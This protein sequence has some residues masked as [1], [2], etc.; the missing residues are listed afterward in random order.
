MTSHRRSTGRHHGR[1]WRPR[2]RCHRF[3]RRQCRD[4]RRYHCL[5]CLRRSHQVLRS[6]RLMSL[7]H[8]QSRPFRHGLI[9][10]LSHLHRRSPRRWPPSCHRDACPSGHYEGR[11]THLGTPESRFQCHLLRPFQG[12]QYFRPFHPAASRR[13][14]TCCSHCRQVR[15]LLRPRQGLLLRLHPWPRCRRSSHWKPSHRAA[16]STKRAPPSAEPPP[17][18]P[19]LPYALAS[20][21]L[22]L[23]PQASHSQR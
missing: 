15:L 6:H 22:P 20:H 2:T 8:R 5:R 10:G 3:R 4:H 21:P 12:G 19:S 14:R 13:T 16:N 18:P 1:R 9:Q 23:P 17:P 7:R 11:S